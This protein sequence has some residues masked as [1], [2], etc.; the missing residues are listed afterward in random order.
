MGFFKESDSSGGGGLLVAAT[1]APA[2]AHTSDDQA[3]LARQPSAAVFAGPYSP[4][5]P[6]GRETSAPIPQGF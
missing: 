3:T 2:R 5:T 1:D 4:L 6:G